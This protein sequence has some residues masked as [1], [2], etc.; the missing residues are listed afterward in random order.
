MKAALKVFAVL[1]L[2]VAA[3]CAGAALAAIPDYMKY[4]T[5]SPKLAP[6][7]EA[8]LLTY[9]GIDYKHGNVLKS[10]RLA[11][12]TDVH[13]SIVTFAGWGHGTVASNTDQV[14]ILGIEMNGAIQFIN[15]KGF[16]I[17][18]QPGQNK[19]VYRV[20]TPSK[21]LYQRAVKMSFTND[22]SGA[23]RESYRYMSATELIMR[24]TNAQISLNQETFDRVFGSAS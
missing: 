13:G 22:Y 18:I 23:D 5:L 17:Y 2:F 12:Q 19:L 11:D 16:Q 24:L 6:V 4:G 1:L 7:T 3:G 15:L 8:Q 14:L 9:R 10:I 20:G 21:V